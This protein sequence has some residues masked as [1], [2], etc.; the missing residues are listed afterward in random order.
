MTIPNTR[1]KID[2]RVRVIIGSRSRRPKAKK[3]SEEL[4]FG[5]TSFPLSLQSTHQ[6]IQ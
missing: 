6:R 2:F 1:R 4:F 3:I 5:S